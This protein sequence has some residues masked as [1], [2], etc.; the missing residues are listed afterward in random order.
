MMTQPFIVPA[1]LFALISI[2]LIL[3][4]IPPNRFY[5]MRTEK[6]L[7]NASV[8]YA[9]N[10]FG[11]WALILSGFTYVVVAFIIP[12]D[13]RAP[14]NFSNW[15]IHLAAFAGPLVVSLLATTRYTKSL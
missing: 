3:G 5:G 9:A 13:R 7:S 8:W 1:V 12:Y 15:G 4:L 10:R 14:D 2:P 11:G 6:T